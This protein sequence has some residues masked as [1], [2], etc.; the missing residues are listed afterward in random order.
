MNL[1]FRGGFNPTLSFYIDNYLKNWFYRLVTFSTAVEN[2][3]IRMYMVVF[4][5]TN[6]GFDHFRPLKVVLILTGVFKVDFTAWSKLTAVENR[7]VR[8]TIFSLVVTHIGF[9]HI[10]PLKVVL[11]LIGGLKW[12]LP[13]DQN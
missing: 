3:L 13:P 5:M 9:A 8:K 1:I 4:V 6:I 7:L 10:R 11:P 2:R 12:F